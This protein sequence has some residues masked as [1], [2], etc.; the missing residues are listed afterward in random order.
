MAGKTGVN[1]SLASQIDAEL[2]L[3]PVLNTPGGREIRR[4]YSKKLKQ[5]SPEFI[6]NLAKE[7]IEVY[8]HRWIAYELVRGH[9]QTFRNL[10]A[11]ELETLGKGIN[12]WWTCDAFARTLAGPA[13]LCGQITDE[14]IHSWALSENFWWRRAALVSTVALNVRS[15]GG[16]GDVPRTLAVCT[17]LVDDPQDMVVKA[18]SWALRE[19]V[20]HDP[21]A[22]RR[23]LQEHATTLTPRVKREVENKL[24]TGLK[25]PKKKSS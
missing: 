17:L 15:Q 8:S 22:V 9:P 23:F 10:G 20:V 2:R 14:L 16:K 18:M 11:I 7:L 21:A 25:N 3:L 12:S 13:W 1:K 5:A 19:L 6:L 4:K 24:Q